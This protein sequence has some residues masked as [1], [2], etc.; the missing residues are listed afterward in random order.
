PPFA[1]SIITSQFTMFS[2]FTTLADGAAFW[3]SSPSEFVLQ[4]ASDGG[5]PREKSSGL[6]TSTSTL[7][8]RAGASSVLATS[9]KTAPLRQIKIIS[10]NAAASPNVPCDAFAP[11][12]LAQLAA[13]SLSAVREPIFT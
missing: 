10:P 2:V 6:L 4:I 11:V 9:K 13:L 8:A 5:I 12:A 7:P 1:G 3:T